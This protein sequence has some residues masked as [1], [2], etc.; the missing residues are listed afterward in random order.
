MKLNQT[1]VLCLQFPEVSN[2]R[3]T[4]VFLS[5]CSERVATPVNQTRGDYNTAEGKVSISQSHVATRLMFPFFFFFCLVSLCVVSK[6]T[7]RRQ[8]LGGYEL[9]IIS[10]LCILM[11]QGRR[12]ASAPQPDAQVYVFKL[13]LKKKIWIYC[14]FFSLQTWCYASNLRKSRYSLAVIN[15]GS[16]CTLR[17]NVQEKVQNWYQFFF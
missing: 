5:G 7:R 16:S 2:L 11:E 17:R 4:A 13:L 12:V 10:F 14:A 1:K 9:W 15:Q 3:N 6:A 8:L